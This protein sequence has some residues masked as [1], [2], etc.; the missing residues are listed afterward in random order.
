MKTRIMLVDDHPVFRSGLK[1][2]LCTEADYHVIAEADDGE[3]A[4]EMAAEANPD[5]IIMDISM[6]G[7]DGIEVTR[8]IKRKIPDIRILMLT[9]YA[10][11]AFL[12]ESLDA[13]A[14]GYVLKRAVD[15]ELVH[16][17]KLVMNGEHYIYPTLIPKLYHANQ[18]Q[19][20]AVSPDSNQAV[21]L[22]QREQEVLKYI[23]LGYTQKEISTEL[24]IS[25]KTV[26]TYKKR[27][28]EKIG[29]KKKSALVRYA[30]KHNIINH[31]V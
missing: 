21:E 23:A 20:D 6:P 13:G 14:S 11:E 17:V 30:L 29:S 5:I 18:P 28:M 1:H 22:S 8:E 4:I 26:D 9:M 31:H 25:I 19:Q 2:I 27:V 3:S 10:D 24:F 7:L 12:K 16:A 15:T